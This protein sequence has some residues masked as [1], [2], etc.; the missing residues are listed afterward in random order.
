MKTLIVY[1]SYGNEEGH[2]QTLYSVLTALAFSA[3]N[4]EIHLYTD[5]PNAFN[6]VQNKIQLHSLTPE[7]IRQWRGIHN[8]THRLKIMMLLNL[9]E[10]YPY[11]TILYLDGDTFFTQ[12]YTNMLAQ[13]SEKTVLMHV[14]EYSVATHTTGQ[15]KRFRKNM[16]KLTFENTP[17]DLNVFMWNAGVIGFMPVHVPVLQK[18]I[19]FVDEIYPQYPKHI[20]K[21]FAVSYF[22]QKEYQ[23][24]PCEAYITHYWNKKPE[25][26]QAIEQFL[27]QHQDSNTAIAAIQKQGIIQPAS[28]QKKKWWQ[29]LFR[30]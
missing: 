13:I 25:Y 20:I 22:F 9:H 17:V 29:K 30:L 14:R 15:M 12:N 27:Q 1:Q 11:N 26:T 19:Q 24:Q 21:Q 5:N 23:L 7:R 10:K 8:F 28:V 2:I 18:V 4:T 6:L 3:Q 16:Q